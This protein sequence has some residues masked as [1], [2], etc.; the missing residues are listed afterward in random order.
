MSLKSIIYLLDIIYAASN[1]L[2]FVAHMS[3]QVTIIHYQMLWL[4]QMQFPPLVLSLLHI[5]PLLHEN[6]M[7]PPTPTIEKAVNEPLSKRLHLL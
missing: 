3:D 6:E 2:S 4:V 5:S 1:C 7:L